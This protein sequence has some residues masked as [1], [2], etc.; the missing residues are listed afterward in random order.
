MNQYTVKAN[1]IWDRYRRG[2][3][4][5]EVTSL[6]SDSERSYKFYEGD[7][8]SAADASGEEL[9]LYNIVRP[10]VNYRASTVAMKHMAIV[11]RPTVPT[12]EA[13][14]ICEMLTAHA[15]TMWER[16]KMSSLCWK[17]VKDACIAGD[18]YLYFYDGRG[19]AQQIDTTDIYFA[20]EQSSDIQS[21]RYII[22]R[23]RRFVSDVKEQARRFGLPEEEIA[24][25]MPDEENRNFIG[26]SAKHEI[27]CDD[28]KC[29]CLLMMTKKD[30]VV[31]ICRSTKDVVFQPDTVID[32]LTLYPVVSM[33]WSPKKGSSRGVGECKW[34][35]PNQIAINKMLYERQT[36]VRQSAYAKPVYKQD[37]ITDPTALER[38]GATIA[39]SDINADDVRKIVTY[40]TP[41]QM[42]PDAQ[43][44]AMEMVNLTRELSGA[45]ETVTGQININNT[46]GAAIIAARDQSAIP[47]NEQGAFLRQMAE[48]IGTLWLELWR[49]YN[50]SGMTVYQNGEA[51]FIPAQKLRRTDIDVRV[52]V[53]ATDPFNKFAAEQAIE[54]ALIKGM[55]SFE[56]YVEALP[57]DA[58]APKNKFKEILAR[59]AQARMTL[60]LQEEGEMNGAVPL[61]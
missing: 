3:E 22:I 27:K 45:S 58:K 42:S 37:T 21:Q 54:N 30:S 34:I 7:Q 35:I 59:R 12:P 28:G 44:L 46:S 6:L 4:H 2:V 20:N 24:K 38:V 5:H 31:H 26:G 56:E 47:L 23:E 33:Q 8:W 57:D 17:T 48:D 32:G 40:L 60:P 1:E 49:I 36:A 61:L 52:D 53:T 19:S 55:I 29:T 51:L 18:S 9:S 50:P 43:S 25:I 13:E 14:K 16:L 15:E 10:I 41:A 39:V 11:Y